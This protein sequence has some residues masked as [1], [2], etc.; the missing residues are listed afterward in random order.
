VQRLP[1]HDAANKL[2]ATGD[3]AG[4]EALFSGALER[5]RS[6]RNTPDQVIQLISLGNVHLLQFQYSAAIANYVEARNLAQASGEQENLGLI[7]LNLSSLYQQVGDV[8]D[9]F[10]TADEARVAVARTG[11]IYFQPQLLLMLARFYS[12][13]NDPLAAGLFLSGIEAARRE[14]D[15]PQE[16]QGWDLLGEYRLSQGDLD[17][18]ERAMTEGFL[19]R[20]LH[21]PADL[22]FSYR[23]LGALRLAQAKLP[24]EPKERPGASYFEA[25]ILL[26][27]KAL[28]G[29]QDAKSMLGSWQ[30]LHQL[31]QIRE[32]Q[33]RMEEALQYYRAAVDQAALWWRTLPAAD[34]SLTGANAA[35]QHQV[36]DSFVEAAARRAR[37]TGDPGLAGESFL[38]EEFNR[39]SPPGDPGPGAGVALQ[40]SAILLESSQSA[41]R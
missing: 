6:Q 1:F 9:A 23:R 3:L 28:E 2:R 33:G 29:S 24:N 34:S 35:L 8:E 18:A 15:V 4:L 20:I 41:S 22:R 32:A 27:N 16:A 13:R 17:G 40:A 25:A 36:F 21:H 11:P 26:T 14:S 5:A 31:G 39:A 19:L 7:N 10:T 38:V 12:G 37:Q 30:L